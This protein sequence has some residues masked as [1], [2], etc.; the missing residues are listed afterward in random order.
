MNS[1]LR[2]AG[3][4]TL[5]RLQTVWGVGATYLCAMEHVNLS[6]R[7]RKEKGYSRTR[8]D[9]DYRFSRARVFSFSLT[10]LGAPI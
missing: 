6:M 3:K 2:H 1:T 8:Y 4:I 7:G 9:L 5:H 10:V